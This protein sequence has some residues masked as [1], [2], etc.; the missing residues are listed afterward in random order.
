MNTIR[1]LVLFDIDGTLVLTGGAGI[2]AMNRACEELVGHRQALANIP[3]AGRTDRIIL[4]D[5]LRQAGQSPDDGLLDRLRDRYVEY[6]QEEI[7]RPGRTQNFESLGARGAVKA[8]MPGI[9]ELLDTLQRRDDVF[10]GLLTGNFH[11]GAR[12]KL[13]HF[14]LWRY[15]RCGAFGDDSADRNDLVPFAVRR[16]KECGVPELAPEHI[17]VVGDT[18]HDIAC[19]RAVGAVPVAVATGGFTADQLR[20]HGADLVFQ[21]LSRWEEFL[22]L[23][24]G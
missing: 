20:E 22:K 9:R 19:A 21:D 5:V 14:D 11:A 3:V 10:L 23:L 17:V 12:I 4:T 18:P 16:A 24:Q 13:E 15:F 8:I 2:R 1:K 6:L 7:E